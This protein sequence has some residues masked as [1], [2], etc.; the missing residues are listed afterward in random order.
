VPRIAQTRQALSGTAFATA[1]AAGRALAYEEAMA[2]A[3][4]WLE[5][6]F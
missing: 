5:N 6:P 3:R 1:E 2:E 4:A